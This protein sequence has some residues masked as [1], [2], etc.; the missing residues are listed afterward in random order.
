MEAPT[1]SS[2]AA[3][4]SPVESRDARLP[5]DSLEA[6]A[7]LLE[8]LSRV[9][10]LEGELAN[11]RR[12]RIALENEVQQQ[13]ALNVRIQQQ[14]EAEEEALTNRL[15]KRLSELRLE[16]EQ[17]AR[18]IE[19]EEEYLTNTLQQRL[20][21]LKKEKIDMENALEAE[22]EAIVNRLQREVQKLQK[23]KAALEK[24]L[25][26]YARSSLDLPPATPSDS[27][28]ERD[29]VRRRRSFSRDSSPRVSAAAFRARLEQTRLAGH[30]SS[31]A[32]TTPPGTPPRP[33][34][35][36]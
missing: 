12:R 13:K 23:E 15:N 22:Q 36:A 7:A 31:S 3:L 33:K 28:S 1:A 14:L 8:A 26:Q 30:S 18:D 17:L 9:K 16:K 27:E 10:E 4:S 24:Q 20:E 35:Q 21:Q 32:H 5:A 25:S 6:T 11:E 34:D 29:I 2:N 19:R